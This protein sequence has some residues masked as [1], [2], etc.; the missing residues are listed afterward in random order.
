MK[1]STQNKKKSIVP[2]MLLLIAAFVLSIGAS[3]FYLKDKFAFE[4]SFVAGGEL[5]S[6]EK[7]G[8]FPEEKRMRLYKPKERDLPI[9][10]GTV[11]RKDTLLVMVE[12]FIRKQAEPYRVDLLDL[13]LDREGVIYIDFGSEIKKN[14]RGDAYE[15]LNIL[16]GLYKGIK[17]TVP[18]LT[19]MK[20]LIEGSEEKSFGGHI[21]ISRPIGEEVMYN[22][23]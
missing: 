20:I 6:H 4:A 15:E 10:G 7:G 11:L 21:D 23:Q 8:E 17:D 16:A 12:D 14:F 13:Y 5:K 1:K 22:V 2:F 18:G 19:A 3:F 9:R